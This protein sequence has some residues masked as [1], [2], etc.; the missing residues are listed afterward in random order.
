VARRVAGFEH[1]PLKRASETGNRITE[2]EE[3]RMSKEFQ[4]QPSHSEPGSRE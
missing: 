1:I 3:S 4:S 2:D